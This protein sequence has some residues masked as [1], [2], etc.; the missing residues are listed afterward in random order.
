ME[1]PLP[2]VNLDMVLIDIYI[3]VCVYRSI[4]TY[5]CVYIYIYS[6]QKKNIYIYIHKFFM[7]EKPMKTTKPQKP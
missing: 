7:Y 6:R 5:I 4:Y 2:C 1:I 3:C